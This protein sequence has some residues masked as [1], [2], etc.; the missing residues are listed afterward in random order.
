M[1]RVA[2]QTAYSAIADE[3]ADSASKN[4]KLLPNPSNTER[5]RPASMC[6][7]TGLSDNKPISFRMPEPPKLDD[8]KKRKLSIPI[9]CNNLA[10]HL[11]G[12]PKISKIQQIYRQKTKARQKELQLKAKQDQV[13]PD[14]NLLQQKLQPQQQQQTQQKSP[15]P[16]QCDSPKV[17]IIENISVPTTEAEDN[18]TRRETMEISMGK[19]SESNSISPQPGCSI[20]NQAP[21][22][23]TTMSC[24]KLNQHITLKHV[25]SSPSGEK[26]IKVCGTRKSLTTKCITTGQK[27]IVVSNPQSI[28]TSSILQRTLTIPFV[29]NISVKNFDKFKIVTTNATPNIQLTTLTTSGQPTATKHKVVTVRTNPTVKKV[30][31]LSQLQVLNAKGSIKVLP[32]GGKIVTK[33]ST[34]TTPV[35]IVNSGNI[36][37]ITKSTTSTPIIMTCKTQDSLDNKSLLVLKNPDII[38]KEAV[39]SLEQNEELLVKEESLEDNKSNVLLDIMEAAGV[40]SCDTDNFG[41]VQMKNESVNEN[42]C[43]IENIEEVKEESSSMKEERTDLDDN[44]LFTHSINMEHNGD[45]KSLTNDPFACMIEEKPSEQDIPDNKFEES[46]GNPSCD[47]GTLDPTTG[48]Y[49]LTT[50]DDVPCES[51]NVESRETVTNEPIE[52]RLN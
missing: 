36:Q 28:T 25:T 52:E 14:G 21:K 33:T 34:G 7:A 32:L 15:T 42:T 23:K 10:Q 38:P 16:N 24:P 26:Q 41:E 8:T 18:E 40:R 39:D 22:S 2:P 6:T 31:P 46:F 35:Y 5:K 45:E 1:P 20:E 17:N 47:T 27:L 37:C 30:I 50:I 49:T 13:K 11:M 4:N 48:L 9:E 51:L 29:K 19:G 44:R 3:V 12:P 43:L